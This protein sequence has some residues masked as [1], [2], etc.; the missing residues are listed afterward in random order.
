MRDAPQANE[1]EVQAMLER[2]QR[3]IKVNGGAGRTIVAQGT[4]SIP[5]AAS[6]PAA[7]ALIWEK[8]I[9][10]ADGTGYVRSGPYTVSK[11]FVNGVATYQ[12]FHKMSVLRPSC[13]SS[14]A[15]KA[16]CQAHHEKSIG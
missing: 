11:S 7:T 14:D 12:G 8:A 6:A 16:L 5:A 10:N 13:E 9:R 3:R 2:M 15:C 1:A 4:S